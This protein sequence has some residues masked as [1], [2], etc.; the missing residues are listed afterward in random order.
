MIAAFGAL[1]RETTVLRVRSGLDAARARGVILGRKPVLTAQ[2]HKFIRKLYDGGGT[3]VPQLADEFGVSIRT[4]WR[5]L[6]RES[7]ASIGGIQ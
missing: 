4:I 5:S 6:A 1:E 2:Q 7:A 3:T